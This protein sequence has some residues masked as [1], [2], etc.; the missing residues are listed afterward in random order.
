MSWGLEH[1]RAW[2]W[3]R[4]DWT[5]MVVFEVAMVIMVFVLVQG[6]LEV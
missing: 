6:E 1:V 3:G 5:C 4:L 2:L